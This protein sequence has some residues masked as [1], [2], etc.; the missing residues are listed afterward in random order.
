MGYSTL[1]ID[2]DAAARAEMAA[3]AGAFGLDVR[4]HGGALDEIPALVAETKPYIAFAG[5]DRGLREGWE[6]V[7]AVHHAA[8][9]LQIVL[10]AAKPPTRAFLEECRKHNVAGFL[11]R[12]ADPARLEKLLGDRLPKAARGPRGTVATVGCSPGRGER[13]VM[14]RLNL[15]HLQ[16]PTC[17]LAIQLFARQRQHNIILLA[18]AEDAGMY[19]N[20]NVPPD[21]FLAGPE[22]APPWK[23]VVYHAQLHYQEYWSKAIAEGLLPLQIPCLIL[24]AGQTRMVLLP[25]AVIDGLDIEYAEG[26]PDYKRIELGTSVA[27]GEI[28]EHAAQCVDRRLTDVELTHPE[29]VRGRPPEQPGPAPAA[30]RK[31]PPPP[32]EPIRRPANRMARGEGDD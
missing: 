24:P 23:R 31:I 6:I 22:T 8:P 7:R 15:R 17:H 9:R 28:L 27:E 11:L 4:E 13:A 1:L 16:Y 5:L 25:E 21:P 30:T 32:G 3:M 20:A 12:P 26:N 2:P 14:A 29:L 19:A 18:V 10:Y